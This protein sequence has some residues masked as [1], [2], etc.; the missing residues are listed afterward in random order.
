MTEPLRAAVVGL[1]YFGRF[2]ARHYAAHPG[3]EL[4]AVVDTDAERAAAI[5]DEF[6]G[7]P[8]TDH[9]DLIGRADVASVAVPTSHHYEVAHALL[10]HGI[11]ALVEKPITDTIAHAEALIECA[12]AAGCVLQVGHIERF[13]AVF[14]ELAQH[15][16]RPLYF[17]ATRIAPY[18][19]RATDVDVV[20]DLMIHD[21]DIIVGLTRSEVVSV[22]AVGAPVLS[23]TEDMANA[24]IEFANGTVANVT[25][26][27]IA[28][29]T[30][31]RMRIFQPDSYLVCD[32]G[33]SRIARFS[34]T[35]DPA[36]EGI[37]A[38][39]AESWDIP[40]EDSLYNQISEFLDCVRGNRV[41]TVDGLVGRDA[42]RVASMITDTLR[43]HRRRIESELVQ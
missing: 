23:P 11:H 9:R 26:S 34:R 22:H 27:R 18:K 7:E 29:K 31:R 6:G 21:I 14:R 37:A 2:H 16:T 39:S 43:A 17:E 3:A 10:S 24:R 4:V 36:R 32:F 42:L 25:A 40:R 33:D 19:P 15:V 5:A 35:G 8:L 1:G 12:R 38:I 28:G 30:E 13:S 20:L 41:P